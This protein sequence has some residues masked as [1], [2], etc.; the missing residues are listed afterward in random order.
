MLKRI[1]LQNWK[2]HKQS[3]FEFQPG[4]NVIIGSMG[5]GKSSILQAM[6]YAIFGTFSELKSKEIKV[7]DLPTRG[8]EGISEINLSLQPSNTE[9]QIV[10]TIKN[11]ATFEATI[12]DSTGQ[13][14]AGTNSM[15][16]TDFIVEK[17]GLDEDVFLRTAYARQNDIDLFLRL[18]PGERKSKLD[19]LMGLH[20]FE[21]ARKNTVRLAN[22]IAAKRDARASF[23]GNFDFDKSKA[24]ITSMT[25]EIFDL[26]QEK[27]SL[28]L[29]IAEAEKK[30][31]ELNLRTRTLRI[32][33][34]NYNRLVERRELYR[35]Q[36]DDLSQKV[37]SEPEESL[38]SV[39]LRLSEIIL[40]IDEIRR[41]KQHSREDLERGRNMSLDI[42]KSYGALEEKNTE[43][44]QAL[45]EID[46]SKSEMEKL[47]KFGDLIKLESKLT[48]LEKL[49]TASLENK[50]QM[51]G[52]IG[53]LN[54]HLAELE[55]VDGVCPVCSTRLEQMTKDVLI[56]ERR[57]K[58]AELKESISN[59]EYKVE[60]H[61]A[62]KLNTHK[63][64]ELHKLLRQQIEKE[65]ELRRRERDI[66]IK[67]SELRGKR[68][69]L[70]ESFSQVST[71][72][73]NLDKEIENLETERRRLADKKQVLELRSQKHK[74]ARDLEA[75]EKAIAGITVNEKS[76]DS[77]ES[78]YRQAIAEYEK[79]ASRQKS[80]DYVIE[81][82]EKRLSDLQ[83]RQTQFQD[84]EKEVEHLGA[85]VDFLYQFKNAL[86]AAQESLRRELITAVNEVIAS[87]WASIYP[88]DKWTAARLEV[89][90]SDYVLQLREY[91]GDWLN[92]A[93]Y[94]SGGERIMAALALRIAF[95]KVLIPQLNILI[96]DEPTHN[97]DDTA[98]ATF[99]EVL[100]N[101]LSSF[102]DQIFIITHNEKLA[103]AGNNVIRL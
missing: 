31:A 32:Q 62:E 88:Y 95:T 49:I 78:Q 59:L 45:K 55:G 96:L 99:V 25:N 70:T 82:K 28:G 2:V 33:F 39:K 35:K 27:E 29:K 72:A 8:F 98:I 18:S 3:E 84:I 100:Q 83:D 43:I 73:E 12:R 50:N 5:A 4:T 41:A 46:E 47:A 75:V 86:L 97:M 21:I 87:I 102:L 26:K 89:T 64:Y 71:R 51:A 63:V 44:T 81:E 14:L 58:I 57:G 61:K 24:E 91:E 77:I 68:A 53:V 74:L 7:S 36:L 67:I 92:V 90:E 42:E 37:S 11:G 9:Y 94:A 76:I 10:R 103:E 69:G 6:S 1:K 54:G 66:I 17:L 79:V 22:Q 65:S 52:E 48:E 20:K 56:Q 40:R 38:E 13:L 15:Q 85:K 34:D 80:L 60:E 19:E 23:V 101:D 93:G 30:K 16:V